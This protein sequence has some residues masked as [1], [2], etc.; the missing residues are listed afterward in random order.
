ME[1]EY[2]EWVFTAER[3]EFILMFQ[4]LKGDYDSY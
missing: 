3:G 4:V 2:E 1:G